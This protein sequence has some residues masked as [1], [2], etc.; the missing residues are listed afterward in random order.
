MNFYCNKLSVSDMFETWS[1][2]IYDLFNPSG[3]SVY[4][5]FFYNDRPVHIGYSFLFTS[6]VLLC[7]AI[8]EYVNAK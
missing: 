4:D 3:R 6:A 8:F 7:V 2:V 1:E 5:A